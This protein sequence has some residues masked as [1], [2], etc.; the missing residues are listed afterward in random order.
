MGTIGSPRSLSQTQLFP[1]CC[2]FQPHLTAPCGLFPSGSNYLSA[3][4]PARQ[5]L[6]DSGEGL[7]RGVCVRS[8]TVYSLAILSSL[9]GGLV[10]LALII[11][12]KFL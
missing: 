1:I 7:G 4:Y 3:A 12:F 8:V 9:S 11:F 6:R 5:T 2:L 10:G